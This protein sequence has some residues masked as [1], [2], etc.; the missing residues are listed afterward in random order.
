MKQ[1][2]IIILKF[3]QVSPNLEISHNMISISHYYKLFYPLFSNLNSSKLTWRNL[4][5]LVYLYQI[6]NVQ[7]QRYISTLLTISEH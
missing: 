6:K 5:T 3:N 1:N 4:E 7:I 2:N